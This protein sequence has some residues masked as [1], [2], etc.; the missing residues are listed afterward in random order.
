VLE[1]LRDICYRLFTSSGSHYSM[2]MVCDIIPDTVD[3][4]AMVFTVWDPWYSWMSEPAGC[5]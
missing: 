5:R 4:T 2:A 3:I 1:K